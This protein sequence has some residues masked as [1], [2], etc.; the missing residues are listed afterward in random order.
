MAVISG[1][2]YADRA[3]AADLD[4]EVAGFGGINVFADQV[5]GKVP[6][7]LLIGD[8]EADMVTAATLARCI[9]DTTRWAGLRDAVTAVHPVA[10]NLRIKL[11][12]RPDAVPVPNPIVVALL[13]EQ[14]GFAIDGRVVTVN[15]VPI[16]AGDEQ[17]AYFVVLRY[18]PLY[19]PSADPAR[20]YTG[21]LAYDAAHVTDDLQAS[22]LL[23]STATHRDN[24]ITLQREFTALYIAIWLRQVEAIDRLI[25]AIPD[26]EVSKLPL[27]YAR[28]RHTNRRKCLLI[29][30]DL[31]MEWERVFDLQTAVRVNHG[32]TRASVK[33]ALAGTSSMTEI[34]AIATQTSRH[35]AG[36]VAHARVLHSTMNREAADADNEHVFAKVADAFRPSNSA[37][38]RDGRSRITWVA[39]GAPVRFFIGL[40]PRMLTPVA[41]LHMYDTVAR[42]E[43]EFWNGKRGTGINAGGPFATR[44]MSLG[45]ILTS[46]ID[47]PTARA[48]AG[49]NGRSPGWWWLKNKLVPLVRNPK[50]VDKINT[51]NKLRDDDQ[52]IDDPAATQIIIPTQAAGNRDLFKNAYG[53]VRYLADKCS[54]PI[55][56]PGWTQGFRQ[57]AWRQPQAEVD[58]LRDC[59][60]YV[61]FKKKLVPRE[62][63]W[64]AMLDKHGRVGQGVEALATI[65][66]GL[67]QQHLVERVHDFH[68]D[69]FDR[70]QVAESVKGASSTE[71]C[72]LRET[73]IRV[74]APMLAALSPITDDPHLWERFWIDLNSDEVK[75]AVHGAWNTEAL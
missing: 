35:V 5:K 7:T 45:I 64:R 19:G 21:D 36:A 13:R 15:G 46:H 14:P 26:K 44:L 38:H 48:M 1:P 68:R 51:A 59:T 27:P 25:A 54:R 40:E 6:G 32:V 41:I 74:A 39:G 18:R 61:R 66:T 69:L 62:Q 73:L 37:A 23:V 2:V 75:I 55:G 50:L 33:A 63:A 49:D 58:F 24:L 52:G 3:T 28:S 70:L 8:P 4:A 57:D 65:R 56:E 12:A 60:R 31:P 29:A 11:I 53:N 10:I 20:I 72:I 22:L 47:M 9:G 42:H 71:A 16:P 43:G 30:T 34:Y 17:T 67:S